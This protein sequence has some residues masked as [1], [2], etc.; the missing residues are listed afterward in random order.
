MSVVTCSN[1]FVYYLFQSNKNEN[2]ILSLASG[3]NPNNIELR[4][5]KKYFGSPKNLY[6]ASSNNYT[7]ITENNIKTERLSH[8]INAAYRLP[9]LE[10]N[11][12]NINKFGNNLRISVKISSSPK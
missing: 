10:I 5:W 11:S 4:H 8:W 2:I 1:F 3:T 7:I 9:G 12:L 6:V